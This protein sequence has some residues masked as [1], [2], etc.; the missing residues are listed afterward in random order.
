MQIHS[1]KINSYI[2][3]FSA[4]YVPSHKIS[5]LEFGNHENPNVIVCAHGLTRNA[6]DFDKIAEGLSNNFR[7]ISLNY[8]GRGES[9]NFEMNK[10]YNYHVYVKDTLLFLKKLNIKKPIWLGSSMG[11][12]IG[13]ILASR[14][15][16]FFKAM[17]LNDI[18]PFISS[19][20]LVKIGRYAKKTVI[21]DDL[22][23]AKQHLKLIYSQIGINNEED[24][25]YLTKYSVIPTLG[26]KY[27]MNYDPGIV[28]GMSIDNTTP[29]DVN[30]WT[31]WQRIVCKLLVIHGV[32]SDILT[33]STIEEMQKTKNFD[34]Y[35][36]SYAGHTPSLTNLDQIN[37]IKSWLEK[38]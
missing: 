29:K 10:H 4:Q 32:K 25:N 38:I 30:M 17:I 28:H 1:I 34:L 36:V 24:W 5:Y 18:G 9:E 33:K 27:K 7:V 21:F 14:Y 6:H 8:P 31:I 20:P 35:E 15:K 19:A 23:S 37:Y 13:M 16:D 22:D 11:G 12:I 3:W 2:N 26:G